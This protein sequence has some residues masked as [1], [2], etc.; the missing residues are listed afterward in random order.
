[1]HSSSA[2]TSSWSLL[3]SSRQD[4]KFDEEGR[5]SGLKQKYNLV[6]SWLAGKFLING[7][8]TVMRKY[9]IHIYIYTHI[10]GGFS[11][12]MLDYSRVP[13]WCSI[14]FQIMALLLPSKG[15]MESGHENIQTGV[16]FG[17]WFYTPGKAKLTE[18][19]NDYIYIHTYVY[20]Y[21][22]RSWTCQKTAPVTFQVFSFGLFNLITMYYYFKLSSYDYTP[23]L[24]RHWSK[25]SFI[26]L[27]EYCL[28][29]Y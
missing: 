2:T 1:M 5:A 26:V 21:T 14:C 19:N 27:K 23:T 9:S 6:S 7:N 22:H 29:Y 24:F 3:G 10:N 20:I 11:I 28:K 4:K 8:L 17:L 15:G 25:L 16:P 13:G 18:L 12:A